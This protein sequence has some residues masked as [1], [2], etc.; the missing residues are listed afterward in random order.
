MMSD[1][2][3]CWF[4]LSDELGDYSWKQILNITSQE[5]LEHFVNMLRVK[6]EIKVD[7]VT[8]VIAQ[9]VDDFNY[10]LSHTRAI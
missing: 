8:L 5:N 9:S 6:K 3:A 1:A 10:E 4:M 7:D 2:L